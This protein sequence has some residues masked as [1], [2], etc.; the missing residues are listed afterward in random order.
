MK[1]I[2]KNPKQVNS[3]ASGQMVRKKKKLITPM[4]KRVGQLLILGMR[5]G[6]TCW[7]QI[8]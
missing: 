6:E 2:R 3:L 5:M 8:T 7:K 1:I 4:A